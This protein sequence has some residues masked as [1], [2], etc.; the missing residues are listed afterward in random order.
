MKKNARST[1]PANGTPPIRA[2]RDEA[3]L[4][5]FLDEAKEKHEA[6]ARRADAALAALDDVFLA[7]RTEI[8]RLR[9][10]NAALKK[11]MLILDPPAASFPI[12]EDSPIND[13]PRA[14]SV[15]EKLMGKSK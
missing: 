5:A 2:K 11:Q 13:L 14:L 12:P 7:L 4:R 9:T 6:I 10:E 1:H 15:M 3:T 8:V